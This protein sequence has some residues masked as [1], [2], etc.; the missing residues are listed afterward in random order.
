MKYFTPELIARLASQDTAE[1]NAAEAEWD[2]RLEH[3]EE[4][5]RR[6]EPDMP[7]HVREFN[8]LLLH[9]A[10]VYSLAR[11]GDQVIMVL[12]KDIPPRDLVVIT[13]DLVGEPAI[14]TEALPPPRSAVMD[15]D[16]DEL[17]LIRDGD[18]KLFTQSILFSN[19]WEVRLTFRD[20]RFVLAA[21]LFADPER[22]VPPGLP[23]SA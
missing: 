8:H 3:Y 9:D 20:V 16:Y 1:V 5:L 12:H 13:Y 23:Q 14:D 7:E 11:R 2:R 15:F 10:R 18:E 6:I 19:G 4:E 17:G 22:A 21:P